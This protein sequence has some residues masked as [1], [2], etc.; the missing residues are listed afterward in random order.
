MTTQPVVHEVEVGPIIRPDPISVKVHDIVC[1][2]FS[3]PQ[4]ENVLEIDHPDQVLENLKCEGV[5][6]RYDLCIE[7]LTVSL[8]VHFTVACQFRNFFTKFDIV[9]LLVYIFRCCLS[10]AIDRTG[11]LHFFSKSFNKQKKS[12]D[13]VCPC[14]CQNDLSFPFFWGGGIMRLY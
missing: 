2:I 14:Y 12:I 10:K 8:S 4:K 6:P 9:L 13:N 5:S 11:V 1:W 7:S 3:S